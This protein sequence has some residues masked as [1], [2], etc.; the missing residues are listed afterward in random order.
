[1]TKLIL[2][3][4]EDSRPEGV[5]YKLAEYEWDEQSGLGTMIYRSGKETVTVEKQQPAGPYHEGWYRR[6]RVSHEELLGRYQESLMDQLEK[7]S[8]G[9]YS[10]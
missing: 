5:G 6:S 9:V 2:Y 8:L 1:M 10:R 7:Q 3:H 4:D